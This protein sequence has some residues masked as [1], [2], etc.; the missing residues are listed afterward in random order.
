M[1]DKDQHVTDAIRAALERG[2]PITVEGIARLAGVDKKYIYR[3]PL[4]LA[5]VQRERE[6]GMPERDKYSVNVTVKFSPHVLDLIRDEVGPDGVEAQFIRDAVAEVLAGRLDVEIDDVDPV[7]RQA[8]RRSNYN[9]R[10]A[11]GAGS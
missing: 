3:R 7:R 4:L 10:A 8:R 1:N 5:I 9:K 2:E 6:P 11:K